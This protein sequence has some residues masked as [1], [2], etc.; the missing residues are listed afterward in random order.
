MRVAWRFFHRSLAAT[1]YNGRFA[2]RGRRFRPRANAIH[3]HRVDC[4][5]P[6]ALTFCFFARS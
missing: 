5:V 3:R 1:L 4:R 6:H 2:S